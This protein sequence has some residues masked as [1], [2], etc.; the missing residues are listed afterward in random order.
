[1]EQ[2]C[3]GEQ[4]LLRQ[5]GMPPKGAYSLGG[6]MKAERGNDSTRLQSDNL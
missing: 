2:W 5:A 1:M 6:G 3:D 4:E